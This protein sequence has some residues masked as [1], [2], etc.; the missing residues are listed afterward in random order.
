MDFL[1]VKEIGRKEK[2]NY[3]VKGFSFSQQAMQKIAIAGETGS[4]KTSVLKMIAGWMQPDEG[5]MLFKG[6]RILG[7]LEQLIPGRKEIAYLSQHFE[8]RNNYWIHEILEYANELSHAH[9][10]RLYEICRIDHLL[11]RRTD[12][13]SGGEKQRVALARLLSTSPQLLLLDEPFSNLDRIHRDI[14]KAVIDDL[15]TELNISCILVSHDAED[16]LA[17]ADTLILMKDGTLIQ[18]GSPEEVYRKPVNEYSA[19]L[20]GAYNLLASVPGIHAG[21]KKILLRPE[22]ILLDKPGAHKWRGI[23]RTIA[24]RGNFFMIGVETDT[25]WIQVQW[26]NGRFQANERVSISYAAEKIHLI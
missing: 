24:F 1:T 10:Q 16:L 22:D 5:E 20:L 9:A 11:N 23:V 3:T 13:L 26:P 25:G 2:G 6:E 19:A 17:W 18:Q 14:I 7:P 12:Q 8:L 15:G 21:G 4:G